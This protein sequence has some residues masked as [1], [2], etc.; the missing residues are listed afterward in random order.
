MPTT[1]ILENSFASCWPRGP[2]CACHL[3]PQAPE[4]EGRTLLSTL[5]VVTDGDSGPGSLP[6]DIAAAGSGDTIAFAPGLAGHTIFLASPLSFTG[7]LS[8]DGSRAPGLTIFDSSGV[9]LNDIGGKVVLHD[10]SIVGAIHVIDGNVE[11]HETTISGG[12]AAQGGGILVINGN[13]EINHSVE[14]D[15]A[16][17]QGGG[18]F[19]AGGNV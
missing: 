4:L 2:S 14:S 7:G 3:P 10:M 9:A 6:A 13:L 17:I 19:A 5:T 16:A 1:P 11:I 18:I 8:L 12:H 15:N